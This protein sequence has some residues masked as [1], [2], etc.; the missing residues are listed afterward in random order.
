M[1]IYFFGKSD[2]YFSNYF[3][4]INIR[5]INIRLLFCNNK[6]YFWNGRNLPENKGKASEKTCLEHTLTAFLGGMMIF[7]GFFSKKFN[8][9]KVFRKTRRLPKRQSSCHVG[10]LYFTYICRTIF[11]SGKRKCSCARNIKKINEKKMSKITHEIVFFFV[12]SLR[13]NF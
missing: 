3:K 4:K 10:R 11:Y 13:R 7:F 2:Y 5:H 9:C 6:T 12:L 8:F 1:E